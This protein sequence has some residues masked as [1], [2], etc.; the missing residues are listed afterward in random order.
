MGARPLAMLGPKVFATTLNSRMASTPSS[1]PLAPP[2]CR[3]ISLALVNSMPFRRKMFSCGR[4]PETANMLPM[5]E[6]EVP[7]PPLRAAV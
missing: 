5:A 7:T 1:S 6:L 3:L 4:W 2:G